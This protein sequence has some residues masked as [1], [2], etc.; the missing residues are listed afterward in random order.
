MLYAVLFLFGY[1][2]GL[3]GTVF[4]VLDPIRRVM[5]FDTQPRHAEYES[6]EDALFVVIATVVGVALL[7]PVVMPL[8][9]LARRK[10]VPVG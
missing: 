10:F 5:G 2:L 1:L 4:V 8:Y 3:V 6:R 9:Y 7:W